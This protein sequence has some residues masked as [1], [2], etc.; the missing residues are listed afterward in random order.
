M[1]SIGIAADIAIVLIAALMGG[2]LAQRLK[3]PLI[4]GYILAGVVVGPHTGGVTVTDIHTIERLA[5]IG[6]ALLLFALGLEFSL[7]DLKPVRYIALIGTPIQILLTMA[8]GFGIG[9]W[10]GRDGISAIWLGALISLSSTMVALKTLENQ[11]WLG[12]LSS[13]VMIGMLIAQDLAIVP[14]MIILPQLSDPKAGLPV[15]GM[16]ALKAALFLALMTVLGT[17]LIPRLM[18]HIVRWNSR[19]LFLL[20][21]VALGLGIGYGTYLFGLSFAFG[22]FVAGLVLSESDYSHQALADILPLRDMFGLLF[23]ASVGMLLDP[24]FLLANLGTVLILVLAVILG[25]GLIFGILSRIFGYGNVVPLAAALGLAQVG[26][27]SFV[28][29]QTGISTNSISPELYSLILTVAIVTMMLTPFLSGL[30]VPIYG[31]W[32]RSFK[33]PPLQTRNLPQAGLNDHIV[34]AGSGRIGQYVA[35]VLQRLKIPVVLIEIDHNRVDQAQKAGF[36]VIY[37]DAGQDI[38]LEAAGISKAKML[39]ITSPVA[40]V[41][42]SIVEQ[43]RRLNPGLFIVARADEIEQIKTLHDL[44]V[45]E[46]VQPEFEAGLEFARQ[47]LLQLDIPV[48]R[49]QQFTDE[50]RRE[51][52]R[53]IYDTH[54]NYKTI[55]QLESATRLFQLSWIS[56]SQKDPLI[57][58]TIRE[59]EIRTRTGATVVGIMRKGT[60]YGNPEPDF[61]FEEEDLVG[62]IGKHQHLSFFHELAKT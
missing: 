42:H 5:E 31:F 26:E 51:L 30:T 53:P 11:G 20:A 14:M 12:T 17:K 55:A 33:N 61:R 44:G 1:G 15:L 23:F 28:L 8:Y 2:L 37:G 57:G 47:A 38:I 13:R 29:A 50:V 62:I 56:L 32:R 40:I 52:Y 27:F 7:K 24:A 36:P 10:L 49:I 39:L 6:V 54:A 19:E 60:L 43:T 35:G 18:R 21:N 16:A 3:Q 9:H 22:A 46:V 4:L 34:I 45:Y 59:L 58:K 48:E 41:S 25:K